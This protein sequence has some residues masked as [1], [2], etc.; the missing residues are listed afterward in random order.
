M[1]ETSWNILRTVFQTSNGRFLAI[2]E[3]L[4]MVSQIT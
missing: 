4:E 3:H 2:G 1:S